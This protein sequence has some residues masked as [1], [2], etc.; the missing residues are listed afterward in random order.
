M[1]IP[2][3]TSNDDLSYDITYLCDVLS[4]LKLLCCS[5]SIKTVTSTMYVTTMLYLCMLLLFMKL[6]RCFIYVLSL[7]KMLL[8]SMYVTAISVTSPYDVLSLL[9]LL[10]LSMSPLNLLLVPAMA[11]M[12]S[13]V[14]SQGGST[15]S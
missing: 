14:S 11:D 5:M 7:L 9:K 15:Y 3:S 12:V 2:L 6:L 8:L 10:L 1:L 4:S 13:E